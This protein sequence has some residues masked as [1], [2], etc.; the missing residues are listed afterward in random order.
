MDDHLRA[1][2][3][4]SGSKP[5]SRA[6]RAFGLVLLIFN[7]VIVA[8]GR[9]HARM[10]RALLRPPAD[11]LAAA[12]GVLAGPRPLGPLTTRS[13]GAASGRSPA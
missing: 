2:S 4:R 12:R 8:T 10:A 5:A 1:A 3:Q 7:Y 9:A 11:P 13:N 6:R